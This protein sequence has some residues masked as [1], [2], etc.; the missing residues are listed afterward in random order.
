MKR[1]QR[2]RGH[3]QEV[4]YNIGRMLHQLGILTAAIYFYEKVLYESEKPMFYIE[5]ENSGEIVLEIADRLTYE[6]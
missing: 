1:Y 6:Y 3:C 5:N 2:L 4:N